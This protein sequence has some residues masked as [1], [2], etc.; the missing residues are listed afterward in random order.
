MHDKLPPGIT[1]IQADDFKT[2]LVDI[3]VVDSNPLYLNET[4]R[5]KFAFS[6]QYPIEVSHHHFLPPVNKPY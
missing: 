1:L 4:Y 3:S 6:P 5:L 2:W